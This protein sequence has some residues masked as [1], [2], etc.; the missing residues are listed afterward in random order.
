MKYLILCL[1]LCSCGVSK[2]LDKIGG[3]MSSM[4]DRIDR[5]TK[6]TDG[7]NDAIKKMSD[8]LG[9]T[10]KGIHAQALSI[11]LNEMLKPEN[12]RYITLTS[13]NTIPMIPSAKGFAE[14]ATPEELA[15]LA[16]IYLSEINLAQ[17]DDAISKEKKDELDLG[18]WVKLNALQLIA[19]FIP[20]K[21][22]KKIIHDQIESGGLYEQSANGLIVLRQSFIKD[23]LL[24][25]SMK[26]TL[27]TPQ[28]YRTAISYIDQVANAPEASLKLYGFYDTDQVGLNQ[29]ITTQKVDCCTYYKQL[30]T[31]MEK[32]LDK[33][34]LTSD[35]KDIKLKLGGCP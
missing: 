28:Q 19:S 11:M 15:G 33:K 18:K 21:S 16:F 4:N 30:R 14:T 22:M 20:D 26:S 35:L 2:N 7:M 5:M 27:T 8:S 1:I 9:S 12:T 29:T 6:N 23:F 25:Q 31:K 34:Y 3:G 10:A 32:E 17:I 13:V 24:D